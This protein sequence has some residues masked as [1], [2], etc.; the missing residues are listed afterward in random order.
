MGTREAEPLGYSEADLDRWATRLRDM[1]AAREVFLFVISGHKAANPAA[2]L[3][4]IQ[5]L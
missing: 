3:A 5:R 1:A 4:L 2:A